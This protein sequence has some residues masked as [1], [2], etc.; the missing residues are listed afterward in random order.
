MSIALTNH[1][2]QQWQQTLAPFAVDE[3]IARPHFLDLVAAY[4]Q[5]DRYYHTL[6]HINHVLQTLLLMP[7]PADNRVAIE[8]AAWFH[9]VIYDTQAI[10]NE[11]QSAIYAKQVLQ[12]LNVSTSTI[13]TVKQ[14]IL[15][16]KN[17]QFNYNDID[18]CIFSDA[19]LAILGTK[20]SQYWSYANAIRQE[21]AWVSDRDYCQGRRQVLEKFLQRDQIYATEFMGQTYE[22]RARRNLQAE[23][24]RLETA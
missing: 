20:S 15:V 2:F 24:Q 3:N 9:D 7:V 14:L 22:L 6:E 10:D 12:S 21:Y 16:T 13:T 5:G 4:S 18:S 8:L 11:A 19:D 1:L 17:H 23:I